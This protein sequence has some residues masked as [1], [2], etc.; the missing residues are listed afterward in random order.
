M[1]KKPCRVKHFPKISRFIGENRIEI[2]ICGSMKN[3]AGENELR[4]IP[5]LILGGGCGGLE[6]KIK[7]SISQY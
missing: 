3:S 6:I 2:V 5:F 1:I 4:A 7:I